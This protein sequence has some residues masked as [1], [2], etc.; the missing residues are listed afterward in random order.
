M[1]DGD[2]LPEL[3]SV[4]QKLDKQES[5]GSKGSKVSGE[6]RCEI[7]SAVLRL[8]QLYRNE[9]IKVQ[10]QQAEIQSL[11]EKRSTGCDCDSGR[12]GSPPKA[13]TAV[14][15]YSDVINRAK[16]R[17][18]LKET[19]P[20]HAVIVEGPKE[21]GPEEVRKKLATECAPREEK[22][23]VLRTTVTSTKRVMVQ[24]ATAEDAERIQKLVAERP[25]LKELK[26][27]ALSRLRPRVVV[28]GVAESYRRDE[29][30]QAIEDQNSI[31]LTPENAR[32]VFSYRVAEGRAWVLE[33]AKSLFHRL[34]DK[35][36]IFLGFD[37][38]RVEPHIR[39]TRCFRC[40]RLGHTQRHCEE[41]Q[42]RCARC[43]GAHTAKECPKEVRPKCVNC[44]E[45]NKKFKRNFDSC[46]SAFDSRCPSTLHHR[47]RLVARLDL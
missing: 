32:P 39:P 13:A 11:K 42:R 20:L 4:L 18:V 38:C 34:V 21:M 26:A 43:G 37:S 44:T 35:G 9:Q 16:P 15:S 14:P 40:C 22:L 24:C 31:G 30:L 41:S 3:M 17:K 12:R 6:V 1:V 19:K 36:R 46:H 29:V 27:A 10:D 23:K 45:A 2:N 25:G 28:V 8:A 5:K 7:L 33:V 47:A